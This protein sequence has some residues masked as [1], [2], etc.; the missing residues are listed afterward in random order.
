MADRVALYLQDAHSL[1][2]AIEYVKYA[3]SRGFEAVWQAESRLVRDAVVILFVFMSKIL[4]FRRR[5]AGSVGR[6][7]HQLF[8]ESILHRI[9]FVVFLVKDII[10]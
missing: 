4:R 7:K 8:D 9:L 3:E 1:Q 6:V 10:F 2:D 5:L